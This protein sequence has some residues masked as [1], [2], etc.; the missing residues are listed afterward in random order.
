M[1]RGRKEAFNSLRQR[2][3]AN[4]IDNQNLAEIQDILE[5]AL[6]DDV[7]NRADFIRSI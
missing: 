2:R 1:R 5:K 6:T 7:L 3:K 4:K